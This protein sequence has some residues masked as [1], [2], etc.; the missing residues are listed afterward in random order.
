MAGE[1]NVCWAGAV[2]STGLSSFEDSVDADLLGTVE[3][4]DKL[5]GDGVA[6]CRL[7]AV[8][9]VLVARKAVDQKVFRFAVVH[10]L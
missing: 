1:L 10:C 6:H 3:E 4:E 2:P 7:P 5:E 9:V 8:Q